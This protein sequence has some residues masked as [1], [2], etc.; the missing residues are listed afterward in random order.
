MCPAN[1]AKSN[2]TADADFQMREGKG[3]A[4]QQQQ[5]HIRGNWDDVKHKWL[6]Q[7]S[8]E[9][10]EGMEET[11]LESWLGWRAAAEDPANGCCWL[12]VAHA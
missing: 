6:L 1:S 10:E 3:W 9:E 5:Q 4:S 2:S 7:K 8:A 12:V 11:L